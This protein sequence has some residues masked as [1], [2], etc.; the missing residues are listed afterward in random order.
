MPSKLRMSSKI[1]K[2][3]EKASSTTHG[4][5]GSAK[6]L[7]CSEELMGQPNYGLRYKWPDELVECR[8]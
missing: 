1:P 3:K 7:C 5:K 8:S 4:E 2:E 6:A